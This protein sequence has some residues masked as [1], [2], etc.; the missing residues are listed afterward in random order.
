MDITNPIL[1]YDKD[2][3]YGVFSNFYDYPIVINDVTYPTTEH[4][5]Q[6]EKFVGS[7]KGNEYAELIRL[8]N[9]PAKAK[10]LAGQKVNGRYGGWYIS[11][12]DKRKINDIIK[13][14]KTDVT[15]NPEW[16]LVR[17]NVMRKAC[18]EKFK[19]GLKNELLNTGD[20]LLVEH[21]KR[22]K[23]WADG[24]SSNFNPNGSSDQGE[25]MLGRILVEIR[26]ILSG[27][28][29]S[30]P[31]DISNWLVPEFLLLSRYPDENI[32]NTVPDEINLIV[33]LMEKNEEIEYLRKDSVPDM[34]CLVDDSGDVIRYYVRFPIPDRGIA[35]DV[36]VN[37]MSNIIMKSIGKHYSTV[38]HCKGG[39]GRTGT[40][41]GIVLG[42]MFGLGYQETVSFLNKSFETRVIKGEKSCKLPQTK[43]QKEQLKR[44]LE[45]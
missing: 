37:E 20:R 45:N 2:E 21:T 27:N 36:L 31:N 30:P 22:D 12:E 3:E 28:Y 40:L 29:P 11:K 35:S 17:D 42:K 19:G 15:I 5:F 32:E 39:K 41:A 23:Y 6:A 26:T 18:F 8:T 7:V 24:G 43:A 44:I 13:E 16:N 38:I 33:N 25:N 1:F 34:T 14:Y 4:Y 9:T 10:Y